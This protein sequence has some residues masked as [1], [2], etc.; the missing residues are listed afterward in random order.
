MNSIVAR[1]EKRVDQGSVPALK[2][3]L[4]LFA[5][6][7]AQFIDSSPSCP[8]DTLREGD[9]TWYAL[10]H[11][12]VEERR[13]CELR[14]GISP[15][16]NVLN[17]EC[18][19][20]PINEEQQFFGP[21][22]ET[23]RH[24]ER[25]DIDTV[26]W[27]LA[28]VLLTQYFR[29]SDRVTFYKATESASELRRI[30]E[31]DPDNYRAIEISLRH[32]DQFNISANRRL[33]LALRMRALD[34]ACVEDSWFHVA[35]LGFIIELIAVEA[36]ESRGI[37]LPELAASDAKI[38]ET[39]D[40]VESAY[41]KAHE[42]LH[43]Y[44]KLPITWAFVS[45]PFFGRVLSRLGDETL[46]QHRRFVTNE[47]RRE[48]GIGGEADRS[49]SLNMLCNDYAFELGLMTSCLDLVT[50]HWG[51]DVTMFDK[52]FDDVIE[53]TT[54]LA[55]ASSRTCDEPY[56]LD[57]PQDTFRVVVESARCDPELHAAVNSE[58]NWLLDQFESLKDYPE[59]SVLRLSKA[60]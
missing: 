25:S 36:E 9:T 18:W 43:P 19:F 49:M 5:F 7:L 31:M 1:R 10:E 32:A 58:I 15:K 24:S 8:S 23:L 21:C 28:Q 48:F 46:N 47:L 39:I 55:L 41:L 54:R 38:R 42:S 14:H 60:A 56:F 17:E 6:S 37:S 40:L 52:P 20:H 51:S 11:Q 33:Q 22:P 50:H 16:G 34:P 30:L 53:A 4:C 29:A 57:L 35:T 13:S 3:S 44:K 12:C 27:T 45:E 59:I 2:R 26:E